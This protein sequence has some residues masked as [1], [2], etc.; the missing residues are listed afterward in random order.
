VIGFQRLGIVRRDHED[1][2]IDDI[3]LEVDL[4]WL[5]VRARAPASSGNHDSGRDGSGR[6][7][8]QQELLHPPP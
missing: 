1:L 3:A 7:H 8:Q 2:G 6:R 5:G 4:G